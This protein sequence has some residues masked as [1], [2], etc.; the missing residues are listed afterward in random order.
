MW[1]KNPEVVTRAPSNS[2]LS[3]QPP[4]FSHPSPYSGPFID[5]CGLAVTNKCNFACRHCPLDPYIK[6]AL[7]FDD[8]KKA[9]LELK[10][11]GCFEIKVTG[12]EPF[13]LSGIWDVL[14]LIQKEAFSFSINTNASLLDH[15]Q[16]QHL[17]SY[18]HLSKINISIY[19]LQEKTFFNVTNRRLNPKL[20]LGNCLELKAAGLNP[21]LTFIA[22]TNNLEDLPLI[23][24]IEEKYDLT[25][26]TTFKPLHRRLDG[27]RGPLLEN[28]SLDRLEELIS[29]G[30]LTF[31]P[32]SDPLKHCGPERCFISSN[33]DVSLCE[34]TSHRAFGNLHTASLSSI[35][36]SELPQ[37]QKP[38]SCRSCMYCTFKAYC[39]RCDGYSYLEGQLE[40]GIAGD[41]P[42]LCTTAVTL[43]NIL[44]H[45]P[46][47]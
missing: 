46:T 25:I 30:L 40:D 7:T 28:I 21:H 14:D 12:G 43:H 37:R 27:H 11:M 15:R 19:G 23:P 8:W 34:L 36:Q 39:S 17:T 1:T 42:Y 16:I 6:D 4:E 24:D 22:T 29:S 20:I 45:L 32:N 5:K 33:G 2:M 38:D 35:W 13:A 41:V 10:T 44:T 18:T 31:S 9:I 3:L 47:K 26:D